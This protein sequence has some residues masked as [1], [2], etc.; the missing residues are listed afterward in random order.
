MREED[1]LSIKIKPDKKFI[2]LQEIGVEESCIVVEDTITREISFL[3]FELTESED[4]K[5]RKRMRL[6]GLSM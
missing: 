5:R 6:I 2:C 4:I 1:V 3:T